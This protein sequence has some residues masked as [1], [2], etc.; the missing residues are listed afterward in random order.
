M[1]KKLFPA[2]ESDPTIFSDLMHKLGVNETL[3]LIDIYSLEEEELTQIQRPVLAVIVIFPDK[4]D[5][6]PLTGFLKAQKAQ[7]QADAVVWAK[8]TID[9][10]CGFYAI[11]HAVCNGVAREFIGQ[12]PLS[13]FHLRF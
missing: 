6:V 2:L 9:N 10:A 5:K 11:L 3:V 12:L 8:Q 4:G 1:Y 13:V 7:Q